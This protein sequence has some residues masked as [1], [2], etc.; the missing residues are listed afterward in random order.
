M[1]FGIALIGL[2]QIGME[3]DFQSEDSDSFNPQTHAS[4]VLQNQH[5]KLIAGIDTSSH[6]RAKF[7]ELT[8][9]RTF[10]SI[11]QVETSLLDEID[12]LIIATPTSTH[13]QILQDI[14][15]LKKRFWIMCEKPFCLNLFEIEHVGRFIDPR[16][17]IINY[18]RRFSKD[19]K[20]CKLNFE[21]FIETESKPTI[22]VDFYGGALRTGS[23]FIDLANLWFWDNNSRSLIDMVTEIKNGYSINYKR[24]TVEFYSVD[25]ISKES[26]ANF[27]ADSERGS[28][29]LS[30][31]KLI[32]ETPEGLEI[33]KVFVNQG[34]ALEALLLLAKSEGEF[35][36]CSYYDA[37]RVH[38]QLSLMP[39]FA[40]T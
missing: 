22:K 31:N 19:I 40:I 14:S 33:R 6:R 5:C 38:K 18:S 2:G 39:R 4:A 15:F 28:I 16:T 24:V 25:P 9:V 37:A 36:L 13:L 34:D 35:N 20:S 27:Y 21:K 17:L 10:G 11:S 12:A 3:I 7:E 23:H 8:N 29:R 1:T 30:R 32:H 26:Y